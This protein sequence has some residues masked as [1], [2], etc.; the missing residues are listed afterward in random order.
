MMIPTWEFCLLAAASVINT[1]LNVGLAMILI[2][3]ERRSYRDDFT[4]LDSTA[5]PGRFFG[6]SSKPGVYLRPPARRRTQ[7]QG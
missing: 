2:R 6:G 7:V 3:R 4:C 5:E 1:A